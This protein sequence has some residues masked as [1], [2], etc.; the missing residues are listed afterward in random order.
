[1]LIQTFANSQFYKNKSPN[2]IK[3]GFDY[4]N[5]INSE[6]LKI[7]SMLYNEYHIKCESMLTLMK[8]FN[9]PSSRTMDIIFRLFDIEARSLSESGKNAIYNDRNAI[10]SNTTFK[11]IFHTAWFGETFCLRSSYEEA[12]AKQLDDA[13][14]RYYVENFRIKYFHSEQNR[15]RIAVPDFYLPDSNTIVEVKSSYWLNEPEMRDKKL[16]YNNLGFKFILN[17]EHQLLENW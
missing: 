3:L 12:Y 10:P 15:Y 5:P 4:N 16:A 9:I 1:M 2:L 7:Q 13:K 14:T 8:K 6:F 17:L 11:I